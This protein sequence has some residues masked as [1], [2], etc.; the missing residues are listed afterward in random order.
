VFHTAPLSSKG[1][2]SQQVR[3]AVKAL[4][5]QVRGA[6]IV[7]LRGFVAGTGDLR[8]VQAIV[9]E[10]F[11][12]RRQT[13]PALTVVRVGELP[14]EGA[15]V[16]LESVSV[17]RKKANPHGLA[18]L[19]GQ[20][21]QSEKAEPEVTP[22]VRKSLEQLRMVLSAATVEPPAVVRTTCFV[23]SL[24]DFPQARGAVAA[25][26]PKAAI[27]IVQLQRFH[28]RGLVECEAVAQL[29]AAPSAPLQVLNT[30]ALPRSANYS[31]AILVSAPKLALSGLQLAFEYEE[32]DARLAFQRL[33]KDLQAVNASP[34]D[35][36][37]SN[38]YPLSRQMQDIASKVRFEFYDRSQ[39]PAS[40][41]LLFEGLPSLDASFGVEVIAVAAE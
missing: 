7:K 11:S 35:I 22:L 5:R 37:M 23:S 16:L 25:A 38:I 28:A 13:I 41:M 6:T 33:E 14:L 4:R 31:Q 39:P 26:F 2:L 1:L 32:S 40:T 36:V 12:E 8:R 3:D 10:M 34:K 17:A 30:D 9:S 29:S 18:F 19:S 21:I 15:Q 20:I 24:A 27:S